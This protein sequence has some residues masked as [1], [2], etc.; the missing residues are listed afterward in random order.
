MQ[1][2][3]RPAVRPLA[4][5]AAAAVAPAAPVKKPAAAPAVKA[6]AQGGIKTTVQVLKAAAGV[7]GGGGLGAFAGGTAWFLANAGGRALSSNVIGIGFLAGAAICGFI[8]W[9]SGAF[10]GDAIEGTL[11]K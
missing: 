1:I 9:K 7:V 5:P 2:Q 8:G 4:R 11:K 6:P 10:W 3:N